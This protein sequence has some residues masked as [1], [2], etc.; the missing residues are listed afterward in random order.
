MNLYTLFVIV[1]FA[2]IS[3]MSMIS[4]IKGMINRRRLAKSIKEIME[5]RNNTGEM[6]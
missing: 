3:I 2:I 5:K 4:I 1:S 6:L